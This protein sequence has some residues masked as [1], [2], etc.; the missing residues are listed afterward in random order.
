[1][2]STNAPLPDSLAV[3]IGQLM[4]RLA[5]FGYFGANRY[6]LKFSVNFFRKVENMVTPSNI[7]GRWGWVEW[8]AL[9]NDACTAWYTKH[10]RIICLFSDYRKR[11]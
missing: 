10:F 3:D 4:R 7:G 2:L 6:Y 5:D 1:M 9:T 11:R 8:V